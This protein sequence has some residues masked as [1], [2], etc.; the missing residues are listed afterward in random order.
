[1]KRFAIGL[2]LSAATLFS[3]PLSAQ[4]GGDVLDARILTG[5]QR[6]DGKHVAA[7]HITLNDGWKTYWRAPGDAGIPPQF[8]WSGSRNLSDVAVSWPTPKR[9]L[10]SGV[11][12]IGYEDALTLPLTLTPAKK[13]KPI[14]LAGE[15]II[16]VCKDVCI[17]MT[18]KLS[19]DL[20][21]GRTKPDARIVAAL[22]DRPYTAA[23]A[24][25]GRV[26]CRISPLTDGL[27][28]RAEVDLPQTGGSELAVIETAN[29]QI[30]VAQS[31]TTR[32]GGRLIA[33][34][35]L[36][37]VEGRSFALD[38]SGLRITVLGKKHAVEIQGCPAG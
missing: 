26:A 11:Q 14:T 35:E 29:P 19:Q 4:Q 8:V 34:T 1:M 31:K 5:W 6:A 16:G 24:N 32:Q 10:Q 13:G 3:L 17:P 21:A 20:P 37:H 38:R 15:V 22:A 9:I 23:E 27:S 30:W 25:V 36:Y 28:L 7:L 2:L 33:E 12:T 18:L